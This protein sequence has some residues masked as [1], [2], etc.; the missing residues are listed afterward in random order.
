MKQLCELKGQHRAVPL[1]CSQNVCVYVCLS[2]REHIS[3]TTALNFTRLS[4][5]V[6]YGCISTCLWWVCNSSC[7]SG[8]MRDATF[9]HS[10]PSGGMSIPLQRRRCSVVCGLYVDDGGRR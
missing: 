8:F 10:G 9:S 7:T 1:T 4:V 2:V 3:E 5:H 6:T